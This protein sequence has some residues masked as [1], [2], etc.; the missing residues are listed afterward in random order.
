MLLST[1]DFD[2]KTKQF[3]LDPEQALSLD[4]WELYGPIDKSKLT[5]DFTNAYQARAARYPDCVNMTGI[6]PS[7]VTGLTYILGWETFL[8]AMGTDP[9]RF[10]ELV[11]R[12]AQWMQQYYDALADADV[13]VVYSHDD[14]AWTSGPFYALSWYRE[15]IFPNIKKF[16]SPLRESGKKIIFVCDGDYTSIAKDIADCGNS[17][18]WFEIFTDLKYMTENF[19]RNHFLIGN[20]DTRILLNGSRQD[21]TDEVGRCMR[22]GK[23]CPGYFMA[24]SNHIPANTPVEA[25][26][27]YNEEYI[28]MSKR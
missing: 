17:G 14:M 25:A 5:V 3:I 2:T 28:R 12:Y 23:P 15:Y 24:V 7:L 11:N 26:L 9:V 27:W 6:Y 8:A 16:W 1:S 21:I 19:G 13:P 18:F 4:F 20:A 22:Y 10:G